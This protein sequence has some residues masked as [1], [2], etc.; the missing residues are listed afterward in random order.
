MKTSTYAIIAAAVLLFTSTDQTL[1]VD[2]LKIS[3]QSSDV[4]LSWPSM[5]GQTHLI[6]FT[7]NLLAPW[8]ALTTGYPA[9]EA[10]NKTT[11]I[12][13]GQIPIPSLF[14][15]SGSNARLATAS[16]ANLRTSGPLARPADGSSS[17][18]PLCLYPPG[19]DL[20]H[21]LISDASTSEWVSGSTFSRNSYQPIELDESQTDSENSVSPE[22]ACGFYR[23]MGV[24]IT[25]GITNN[26]TLSDFIPGITV[27]PD[28]AVQ[29]LQLLVDGHYY[30]SQDALLP[31]FTNA[32][33]FD[34]VDTARIT[35]GQHTVQVE[36]VY[37]VEN[38]HSEGLHHTLS[39]PFQV[40]FANELSFPAWDDMTEDEVC[41]FDIVSA[42]P[43]VNWEIDVYNYFDYLDWYYGNT[44]Y[45]YPIHIATGSS[46]NGIIQHDW[47]LMD[48]SG[49][50]RKDPYYDPYFVSF[51]Y[52]AWSG[53]SVATGTG[54]SPLNSGSA[55]TMNPFKRQPAK[56]PPMG[57]WVVGWQD[58]FRHYYDQDSR[59]KSSFTGLLNMANLPDAPPF[60]KAPTGGT[61]AQ[62]FPIRY[63]YNS[64]RT[65]LNP[66]NADFFQSTS[67]DQWLFQLM[68][69]DSRARNL[70]F[71][72]HGNS[73]W[74]A[75]SVYANLLR[76]YGMHRYRFV[77]LDGCE[78]GNGSWPET[79]GINGPGLFTIDY[80]AERTKRPALFVGNKYSTP[81]GNP[82]DSDQEIGGV[83]YSGQIPR[84]VSEFHIQFIFFWQSMGQTYNVAVQ[85]AQDLVESAYPQSF[86]HYVDG[87]KNGQT[88]WPG[89]DQVRVGYEEM[90][91]NNYNQYNDIPRP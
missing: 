32:I 21:F 87:P 61:N 88:Y 4:I 72:G 28:L 45:I 31:P 50:S 16:L 5:P 49:N 63:F 75:G 79:F 29:Y 65:D 77:W 35:N 55:A 54:A 64:F 18:V 85:N 60:W 66:T 74:I 73:D 13:Y 19:F 70:F 68:L 36:A 86:M 37:Q 8:T 39:Q 47:N 56:W 3:T 51:T 2:G 91:Y 22:P 7:T 25:G 38:P 69:L 40:N 53:S 89:N 78:T 23:V 12:H 14:A 82:F 67:N 26:A 57:H 81:I 11:F 42:H 6:L 9:A 30:P 80:Y 27:K 59:L 48:D 20:S 58:M 43:V 44:D 84:S 24:E 33:S 62:T 17:P 34:W 15:G 1:A 41:G 83:K 90:R 71:Y 76:D 52:T 46:T 10:T